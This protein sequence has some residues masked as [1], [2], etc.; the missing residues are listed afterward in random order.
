MVKKTFV[1]Q[2]SVHRTLVSILLLALFLFAL[3]RAGPIFAADWPDFGG[4]E[5]RTHRS[6]D[7][8]SPPVTPKWSA[9]LGRSS[10]Q[11]LVVGNR[12]YHL[13]GDYLWC[14]KG[15]A[16]A[17]ATLAD[18]LIW[19]M[20]VNEG[21]ASK[22][23]PV[24]HYGVIYFGTG[25]GR[26]AA[27]DANTGQLLGQTDPL[28]PEVVSAPLVFNSGEVVVG[29][30]DGYV[31]IIRGLLT[32]QYDPNYYYLGGRVTA[33]PVKIDEHSFVI[34][35]DGGS[36][37]VRA[38]YI[39][40]GLHEDFAPAWE[41]AIQ[42]GSVPASF[43]KDGGNVYFSN[44][45]GKL[46]QVELNTGSI[47]GVN[48]TF[49]NSVS[50]FINNSP[51][52]GNSYVYYTI[53]SYSGAGKVIAV[54]KSNWYD[55]V[56]SQ[57][58]INQGNTAP[59]VWQSIGG[60]LVGD[61]GSRLYAFNS[62]SDGEPLPFAPN[63]GD[64]SGPLQSVLDLGEVSQQDP[65][66]WRQTTGVA[67][68]LTLASGSMS[69]GLLLFGANHSLDINDG[70]LFVY[71]TGQLKNLKLE[72]PDPQNPASAVVSPQGQIKPDVDKVTINFKA[73][74]EA[75]SL[76][77]GSAEAQD[78]YAAWKFNTDQRWRGLIEGIHL[79]PD[80]PGN[81][82]T[83][84]IKD[85]T[86]P[87][88]ATKVIVNIN[89]DKNMP[90]NET[91]WEDNVL[92]IPLNVAMPNLRV[93]NVQLSPTKPAE[94]ATVS[95]SV[96][97]VNDNSYG[98][99][100]DIATDI[101]WW[102]DGVLQDT[103]NVNVPA[104][105]KVTLGWFSFKGTKTKHTV[106]FFVNP[107]KNKPAV[108][109]IYPDDNILV[110]NVYFTSDLDLYVSDCRGGVFK[111]GETVA[112]TAI[113]GS[114]KE[115]TRTVTDTVEFI[116]NG[117]TEVQYQVTL[118]PG[119]RVPVTY[120]WTAPSG[121]WDG[122]MRVVINRDMNPAEITYANNVCISQLRVREQATTISC[123]PGWTDNSAP[124]CI[125]GN[126]WSWA[127][128]CDEYGCDCCCACTTT[129]H[130][131][132]L[133]L[134]INNLTPDTVKA[135]MGFT[136]TVDT[137]YECESCKHDSACGGDCEA[138]EDVDC[139]SDPSGGATEVVAF[140]PEGAVGV[141]DIGNT[142]YSSNGYVGIRMVPQ[143]ARGSHTN[144]WTLPR[145]VIV[146][147]NIRAADR[148]EDIKYVDDNYVL[149]EG[150]FDGG[151]K[152]YTPFPTKDGPYSFVVAAWGGSGGD[153]LVDC[154]QAT[155]TIQGS[156]Y[157]DY[158]VRRVD[159]HNPFPAGTGWNWVGYVDQ[160]F[161]DDVKRFWDTWGADFA[162][163]DCWWNFIL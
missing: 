151:H 109:A 65:E 6:E 148:G 93:E 43:A 125:G 104:S 24:Y 111:S 113:A 3:C 133:N 48:T 56:W 72:A 123:L 105:G 140:F 102:V 135:G 91:S 66:W 63:P 75:T 95:L 97:V 119:D 100:A 14:L 69:Q 12:I 52:V 154:Q 161:T 122:E 41:S 138:G 124:Y 22:S 83:L 51:A 120:N 40:D 103:R 76:T 94:G 16:P 147:S 110:K 28:A 67:T 150:E 50:T 114:T 13:A 44:K 116:I 141:D 62:S 38:F 158:V 130:N 7:P 46:Y 26:V 68:E 31:Y 11:P 80:A 82:V 101:S 156:P 74:Y 143:K 19:N 128:N 33:S 15:D 112:L 70:W 81:T 55:I 157:D 152:H 132:T 96:D 18:L 1:T 20:Q 86:V 144:T 53:R 162:D 136:F 77:Q 159:P 118:A 39:N 139:P 2:P 79:E 160:F 137:E 45:Y 121:D 84:E 99:S 108:E 85:I 88:G 71:S 57:D 32:G 73:I 54:N 23:H 10:S 90:Q 21:K 64:P 163:E 30:S 142:F 78:T 60:V 9:Q 25:G 29:T 106:K 155:V 17:N 107:N 37:R 117:V 87:L 5:D 4:T 36:G 145:V 131:E 134:T 58:L 89:P 8:M 34:G 61:T 47:V 149:Q 98:Y 126:C 129:T 146:P 27:V 153:N 127:C 115:S 42:S 92:E 49:A 35:D 59:L